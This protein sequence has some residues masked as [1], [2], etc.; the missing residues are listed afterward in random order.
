MAYQTFIRS[1][2]RDAQKGEAGYPNGLVPCAGPR[3][4]GSPCSE[5]DT[6]EEAREACRE[7]N[8]EHDPGRY[9]RKMEFEEA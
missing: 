1:W 9:S 4:T 2:W 3:Y 6:A 7:Y 5:Y 8:A